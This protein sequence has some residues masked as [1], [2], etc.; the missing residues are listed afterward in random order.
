MKKLDEIDSKTQRDIDQ[1]ELELADIKFFESKGK[2]EQA[3]L[4]KDAYDIIWGNKKT[5]NVSGT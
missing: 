5:T 3:Q 1:R 2:L 4:L